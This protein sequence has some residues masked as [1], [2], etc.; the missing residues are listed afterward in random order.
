MIC[1]YNQ[2]QE[3]GPKCPG[4]QGPWS[5]FALVNELVAAGEGK[6]QAGG[7]KVTI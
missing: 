2:R 3:G 5:L 7:K 1:S 6:Q 4:A